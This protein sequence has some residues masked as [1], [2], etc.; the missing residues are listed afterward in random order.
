MRNASSAGM[1]ECGPAC[2]GAHTL[3]TGLRER[4]K[5]IKRERE[6]EGER[7]RKKESKIVRKRERGR[8]R[9]RKIKRERESIYF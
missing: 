8:E 7:E 6:K 2:K 4:E 3:F 9:K 1:L 5:E